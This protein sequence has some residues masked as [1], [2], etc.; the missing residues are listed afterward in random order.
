MPDA[1]VAGEVGNLVG[2]MAGGG[3]M[4]L[5]AYLGAK[6]LIDKLKGSNGAA[7]P[8]VSLRTEC[9]FTEACG[10]DLRATREATVKTAI[11]MEGMIDAV[12][13]NTTEQRRTQE[14]I[15]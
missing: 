5:L 14:M 12:R 4:T 11:L 3:G 7:A 13:E 15:R 6:T 9:K 2:T 8:Q 10:S 1:T